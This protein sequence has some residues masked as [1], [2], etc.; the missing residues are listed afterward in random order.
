[1]ETVYETVKQHAARLAREYVE[2]RK[3]GPWNA[4]VVF[5]NGGSATR[6]GFGNFDEARRAMGKLAAKHFAAAVV[7]MGVELANGIGSRRG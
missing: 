6:A 2:A 5:A 4:Y 3:A 1:M 7:E